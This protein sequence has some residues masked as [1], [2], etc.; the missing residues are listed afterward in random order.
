MAEFYNEWV[1]PK[2]V[3][4]IKATT[5]AHQYSTGGW[6]CAFCGCYVFY[7][8]DHWCYRSPN[9]Q[10]A[11]PQIQF[12]YPDPALIELQNLLRQLVERIDRLIEAFEN[13]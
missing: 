2:N 7:G 12:S 8:L 13:K 3:E 10:P 5:V 6:T 11:A 9:P 1:D 4:T